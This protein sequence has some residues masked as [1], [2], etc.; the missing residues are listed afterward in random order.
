MVKY[1]LKG[2]KTKSEILEGRERIK[3]KYDQEQRLIRPEE[4][5]AKDEDWDI[6]KNLIENE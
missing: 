6:K 5:A 2:K 1:K 3:D 4:E